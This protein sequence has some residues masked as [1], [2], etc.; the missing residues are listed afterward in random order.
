M[1]A[2]EVIRATYSGDSNFLS[3]TSKSLINAD[4]GDTGIAYTPAQIRS[5]Y[6]VNNLTLDGAGQT[7]AIVNAYDNPAIYQALDTFDAQFGVTASGPTLYDQYGPSSSFLSVVNESGQAAPLPA[8]D[9]A[10][11]G[12]VNW[13]VEESL[14]L[15]WAHALGRGPYCARRGQQPVAAG[16]DGRRGDCGPPAGRVGGVDELGLPGR[17]VGAG[18]GRGDV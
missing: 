11:P 1:V 13:E 4:L 10:G 9:P 8:T 12:T 16:F 3:S 15:E 6:G 5:A 7:I 17:R 2:G 14:D 18:P